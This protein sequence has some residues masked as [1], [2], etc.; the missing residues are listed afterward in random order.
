MARRQPRR[1]KPATDQTA[2]WEAQIGAAAARAE[3]RL[4]EHATSAYILVAQDDGKGSIDPYSFG[5]GHRVEAGA[6]W[7]AMV[8][9][10]Q[11]ECGIIVDE[12]D[13]ARAQAVEAACRELGGLAD[14]GLILVPASIDGTEVYAA[15]WGSELV[16]HSVV[17]ELA[18]RTRN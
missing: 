6:L 7:Q 10:V 13:E 11:T 18:K 17:T 16:V 4:M 14:H 3:A 5:I 1:R 8:E 15:N 12:T 2:E 9:L